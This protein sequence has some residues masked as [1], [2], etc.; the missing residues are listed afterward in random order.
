MQN[1]PLWFIR[2]L[3]LFILSL[4]FFLLTVFIL[5]GKVSA[6][7]LKVT[8]LDVGQGDS[9][10]IET[11]TENILIDT[12][13]AA[14]QEKLFQQLETFNINRIDRLILTH[15]HA[16]HIAN[17]AALINENLI[18][19]LYD[20]GRASSSFYYRNYIQACI[21]NSIPRYTLREGDIF[22]LA[23][24]AYLEVLN[25]NNFSKNINDDS[26]VCKLVYGDFS[27]LFTGDIEYD[28]EM[29]L[30]QNKNIQATVLKAAHHGSKTSNSLD[31]VTAV[32]PRYVFISA[33]AGNKFGHPHSQSLENFS[34][35]GVARK[36]TFC[37]AFNGYVT[38][39]TNG[40]TLTVTPQFQNDWIDDYLGYRLKTQTIWTAD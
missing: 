8:M 1:Y 29:Y 16:D 10:L 27:M 18:T 12:G 7:E 40:K 36:K 17:A 13:D 4:T 37:T 31:F 9:F 19:E 14:A 24:G 20:N 26:V 15:P 39:T 32:A 34:M 21:K 28:T 33:A 35:A 30:F 3:R 5:L 25:S 23:D 6:A 11:E 22:F 38:I 2:I